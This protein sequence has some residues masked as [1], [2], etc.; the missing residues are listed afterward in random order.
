MPE[1]QVKKIGKPQ[2]DIFTKDEISEL[3]LSNDIAKG[4]Y[5]LDT[6]GKG[7]YKLSRIQKQWIQKN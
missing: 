3:L 5:M 7:S 2:Q 6:D 4:Q 1:T